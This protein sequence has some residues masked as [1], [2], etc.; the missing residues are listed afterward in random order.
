MHG[1]MRGRRSGGLDD[2]SLGESMGEVTNGDRTGL[3]QGGVTAMGAS[4]SE[5]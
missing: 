1:E 5:T 3:L 2:A 4:G